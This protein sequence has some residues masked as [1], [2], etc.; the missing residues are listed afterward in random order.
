MST[1]ITDQA[2]ETLPLGDSGVDALSS[3]AP[4]IICA[5]VSMITV[6]SEQ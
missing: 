2:D 6:G 1:A 5:N 4:L 3:N